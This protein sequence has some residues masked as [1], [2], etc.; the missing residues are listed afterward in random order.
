MPSAGDYEF[1]A[2]TAPHD[3]GEAGQPG[4]MASGRGASESRAGFL[5]R[6][7]PGHGRGGS[8]HIRF[9]AWSS[10]PAHRRERWPCGS[11][12]SRSGHHRN[13]R[14]P[15]ACQALRSAVRAQTILGP[16]GPQPEFPLEPSPLRASPP[17]SGRAGLN[18]NRNPAQKDGVVWG[19]LHAITKAHTAASRPEFARDL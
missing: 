8:H 5:A 9:R 4:R 6:R 15:L 7:E 3:G 18:H 12:K 14:N 13:A 2:A 16:V 19:C 11:E 10:S 1:S 17:A